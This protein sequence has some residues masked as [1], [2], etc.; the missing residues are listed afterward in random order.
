MGGH[1]AGAAPSVGGPRG[2]GVAHAV[3]PA[4]PAG[5]RAR[6]VGPAGRFRTARQRAAD[7]GEGRRRPGAV[8]RDGRAVRAEP[9]R[10]SRHHRRD[11]RSGRHGLRGAPDGRRPGP[12]AAPL[13]G[14]GLRARHR[15]RGG[16]D[17]PAPHPGPHPRA[18]GTDRCRAQ[19]GDAARRRRARVGP[20][21]PP[22]GDDGR[23]RL[24]RAA[25][26]PQH[27]T[28]DRR[29]PPGDRPP[30]PRR[31]AGGRRRHRP[32]DRSGPRPELERR[33]SAPGP[34]CSPGRAPSPTGQPH[35]ARKRTRHDGRLDAA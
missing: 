1:P 24:R 17:P 32:V 4:R 29:G 6:R 30:R 26:P 16:G 13:G 10:R 11:P 9:D 12:D 5:D 34:P 7:T 15:P 3:P 27:G 25:L 35:C 28:Q 33:R 14:G 20:R 18:G 23:S 22:A 31:R 2:V 21:R 19:P 8:G